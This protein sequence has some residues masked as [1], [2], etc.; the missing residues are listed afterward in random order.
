MSAF[1]GRPGFT[2]TPVHSQNYHMGDLY[3]YGAWLREAIEAGIPIYSPTAGEL[4]GQPLIETL[5]SSG[6]ILAALPGYIIPDIR[7]V[8]VFDYAF[9]A[10]LFFS[11]G[12]FFAYVFTRNAWIGLGTGIGCSF[13]D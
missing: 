7:W 3:Y 13:Y 2:W 11:I 6:I 4:A 10:A 12:Y 8:I 9:S 5:R 1:L